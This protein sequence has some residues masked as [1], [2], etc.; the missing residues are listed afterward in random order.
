MDRSLGVRAVA[1]F[2]AAKGLAVLLVGF[3]LFGL[4][5]RDVESAAERL[6][7]HLHLDPA[8]RYPRIFLDAA[9]R[10]TPTGLRLLAA[11]A[12]AYAALR[13][14]EAVGLWRL[15]PW[16]EWLGIVTG[17]IY[18]PFEVAALL[19]RP[20]PEPVFALL[21]NVAVVL[22]LWRALRARRR[23][24]PIWRLDGSMF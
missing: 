18:L 9:S 2:E 8:G 15:R 3:G 23:G 5:H 16:A 4:V 22:I 6:I 11:G 14:A 19:R 13:L 20:G 17:L 24:A 12:L 10:A 21:V 7:A 1:A